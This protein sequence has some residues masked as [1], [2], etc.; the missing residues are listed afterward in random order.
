MTLGVIGASSSAGLAGE[1]RDIITAAPYDYFDSG[2]AAQACALAEEVDPGE[3]T[4]NESGYHRVPR[5][6]PADLGQKLN[7]AFGLLSGDD[8]Q[9]FL[10][11]DRYG[12]TVGFTPSGENHPTLVIPSHGQSVALR[13]RSC[14]YVRYGRIPSDPNFLKSQPKAV[15]DS[16]RELPLGRNVVLDRTDKG[17]EAQAVRD[18]QRDWEKVLVV[19]QQAVERFVHDTVSSLPSGSPEIAMF[20]YGLAIVPAASK[21]IAK[22][23]AAAS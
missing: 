16:P 5:N 1:A 13:L 10:H 3:I 12:I 18:T 17:T 14:D 21:L 19:G 4:V 20:S 22:A 9:E 11:I 7:E 6:Y 2:R 23:R 15:L 8:P